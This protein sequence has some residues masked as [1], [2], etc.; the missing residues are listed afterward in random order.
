M[1]RK[2]GIYYF[3]ILF[4]FFNAEN[5][6]ADISYIDLPTSSLSST[7]GNTL[8]SDMGNPG[9]LFLNPANIWDNRKV[10]NKGLFQ[11]PSFNINKHGSFN[12]GLENS[13]GADITSIFSTLKFHKSFIVGGGIL[14]YEVK[15]L[16]EYDEQANFID[17]FKYSNIMWGIGF[18]GKTSIIQWGVSAGKSSS[19]FSIS[20]SS[21]EF[22]ICNVG[23]SIIEIP[24]PLPFEKIPMLKLSGSGN[25]R[26]V[27]SN[28]A[29]KTTYGIR[30][31][32]EQF[33]SK[34]IKVSLLMDKISSDDGYQIN[35]QFNMGLGLR[36]YEKFMLGIGLENLS[37]SDNKKGNVSYGFDFMFSEKISVGISIRTKPEIG[38]LQDYLIF[39]CRITRFKRGI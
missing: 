5:L 10:V 9:S 32:L 24:I 13:Y 14:N 28:Y 26:F 8:M 20:D 29:N 22:G 3:I 19:N 27:D 33:I 6:D 7:L 2:F 11:S 23:I 16:E 25:Y 17:Y 37:D 36:L 30:L 4:S 35:N 31:D 21:N 18:A 39:N 12:N 1:N 38:D 15:N 34:E